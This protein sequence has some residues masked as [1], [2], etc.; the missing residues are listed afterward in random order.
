[1]AASNNQ[2]I[3]SPKIGGTVILGCSKKKK[4]RNYKIDRRKHSQ[5]NKRLLAVFDTDS[6]PAAGEKKKI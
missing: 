4:K 3:F 5:T 1:M 6:F 2:F